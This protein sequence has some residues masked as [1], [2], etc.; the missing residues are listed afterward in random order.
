MKIKV[1][2]L[3]SCMTRDPFNSLFN[4]NYKDF[5]KLSV[6]QFHTSIISLMS[7]PIEYDSTK[8][9]YVES[10]KEFA[11][12]HFR[13]ELNKRFLNDLV[14][15]QPDY[16][17][18]D[19]YAD[20]H[21]GVIKVGE[22]YLT[23]KEYSY[24]KNELWNILNHGV[25]YNVELDFVAFFEIFKKASDEFIAF[26]NKYLKKTIIIVNQARYTYEY[27][28]SIHKKVN[29][30]G[31]KTPEEYLELN[32]LWS[33]LD[34]YILKNPNVRSIS[35]DK[36]YYADPNYRFGG[37]DDVHYMHN[38]YDDFLKKILAITF[39]DLTNQNIDLEPT[40][41]EGNLIQ[42]SKFAF[43]NSSWKV[44][45]PQIFSIQD[46]MLTV[47][48]HGNIEN[49]WNQIVSEA[50]EVAE[51]DRLYFSFKFEA[52]DLSDMEDTDPIVIIRT[53]EKRNVF[54]AKDAIKEIK[55]TKSEV[56]EQLSEKS[57]NYFIREVELEGKY[58]KVIPYLKKN[59]SY[60]L[61][62][63]QLSYA[64]GGYQVALNELH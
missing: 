26:V 22:S 6:N 50:I 19:F 55:I 8:F 61:T 13:T 49:K 58:V 33:E 17:I 16:L 14:L 10:V 35:Y 64:D 54:K 24:K 46:E 11:D 40:I 15:S 3:G 47:S 41:V 45:N 1:S 32:K 63:L 25:H 9:N 36:K 38:Y 34:N 30:F 4:P 2:T 5:Y 39:N 52:I 23:N 21:F 27:W 62:E 59:G 51:N 18:I 12:W 60:N 43:G 42:N 20:I 28:D 57:T 37:L 31:R 48:A 44:F 29:I 53:F 7:K 56:L